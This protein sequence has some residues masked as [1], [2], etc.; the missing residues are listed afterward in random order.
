PKKDDDAAAKPKDAAAGGEKKEKES[1][2]GGDKKEKEA[3]AGGGEK[4]EIAAAPPAGGAPKVEVNKMEYSGYPY[5][6]SSYYWYD[7]GHVYNHN[8]FVMEAQAHQ[9]HV[10][11][12]SSSHGYAVPIEHHPA[13]Q[14]FSDEN[15]NGCSVM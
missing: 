11:Q 15:P 4:K 9:A 1:A 6:P 13:P 3:A 8:K 10:S 5:P 14:M 12:G 7:E 2:G